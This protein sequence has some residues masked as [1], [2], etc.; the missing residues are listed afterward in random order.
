MKEKITKELID[1]IKHISG[2]ELTDASKCQPAADTPLASKNDLLLAISGATIGKIGIVKRYN[3]LA[4][5]GNLLCLQTK[6]EINPH[7]LLVV[8]DH[9]IGQ[10]QFNRWITGS[11]NDHL[12]PRDVGRILVPRLKENVE[13]SIAKLIEESLNKRIEAEKLID[14]AKTRVEQLIEEAVRS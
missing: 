1:R 5:S 8:L 10:I 7:Y 11:T 3:Q 2:R 14:K 9:S 13:E 6:Q 4:F 12:F